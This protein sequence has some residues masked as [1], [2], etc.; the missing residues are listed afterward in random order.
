MKHLFSLLTNAFYLSLIVA[1][2]AQ[3]TEASPAQ[4]SVFLPVAIKQVSRTPPEPPVEGRVE[5]LGNYDDYI[6]VLG[7]LHIVGEV[8]NRMTHNVEFVKIN[9][10]F[11]NAQSQIVDTEFTYTTL[12]ILSAGDKTCFHGI[13]N[14]SSDWTSYQFEPVNYWTTDTSL[15]ALTLV[16]SHGQY[17]A[18]DF[19]EVVGE[20]RND[21]TYEVQY[22]KPVVTFYNVNGNVV[23]CDFTYVNSTHLQPGQ[24][25][26][27]KT[28]T[29]LPVVSSYRIQVDGWDQ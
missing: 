11:Y 9:V 1:L 14:P 24:T 27:F 3:R 18:L 26:A 4:N 5:I 2:S 20:V 25:S 7:Y 17:G 16:Y 22:V 12:D 29:D 28:Y 13:A 21:L 8:Q 6:D 23:G 19:Y 15:P 10:N